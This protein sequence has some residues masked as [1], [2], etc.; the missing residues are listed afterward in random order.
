VT[1]AYAESES[2]NANNPKTS[3][4][5]I[6][7]VGDSTKGVAAHHVRI[8]DNY[9]HDVPG[10]GIYSSHADYLDIV[11]NVVTRCAYY[12]PYD[13]SGISVFK[14][15][16]V[17]SNIAD[18]KT[19]I[20]GNRSFAN[21]NTIPGLYYQNGCCITDGNGV[22]IDT[23]R[24][25][26][27][28]FAGK[29]YAGRTLIANNLLYANGG[30]GAHVFQSDHVDVVNN[31]AYQNAQ[32]HGETPSSPE[33]ELFGRVASALRFYNNVLWARAGLAASI[34][35][36]V[37]D[38]VY[39]FNVYYDGDTTVKLPFSP[40][41][42]DQMIDPRFVAPALDAQADF[43]PKLG[44]PLVDRGTSLLAPVTDI[45][46]AT[47][48]IGAAVDIGAYEF[49][50]ALGGTAGA[51]GAGTAGGASEPDVADLRVRGGC[52]CS[53]SAPHGSLGWA[54]VLVL[55]AGRRCKRRFTR[56]ARPRGG[57]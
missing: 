56:D 54:A 5:G 50:R 11:G 6:G 27:G 33:G 10:G 38:V 19:R 7:I 16:D 29:A 1:L 46:G 14:S 45:D 28:A 39:D 44:S 51:A 40:G 55:G 25:P 43:H 53:S 41:A 32:S 26:D 47:R 12:S 49:A 2:H 20:I 34:D 4:N 42:R 30:S 57:A 35:D 24:T 36:R 23:N 48:P 18:Y 8:V 15:V 3:A 52:G 21:R 13:N 37:T 22:I 17:D 31:V 9:V